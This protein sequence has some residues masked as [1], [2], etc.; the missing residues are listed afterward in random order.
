MEDDPP[1]SEDPLPGDSK[2]T[3]ERM[4][5][6]V[7]TIVAKAQAA[8]KNSKQ[9]LRNATNAATKRAKKRGW[10]DA[11]AKHVTKAALNAETV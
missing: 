3:L 8:N 10:P 1:R 5:G 7:G 2:V 4:L 11:V 9:N 6:V